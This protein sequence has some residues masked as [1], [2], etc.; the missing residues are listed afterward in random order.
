MDLANNSIL[1]TGAT[2]GLG[3]A[4]AEQFYNSGSTVI[5][6]GRREDRLQELEQQLPGIVTRRADVAVAQERE[7]LIAWAIRE[8]PS[9]NMLMNNAGMQLVTDVTKPVV[10]DLV[11]SEITTNL[12][13]PVHLASLAAQHLMTRPAAAIINISSGLAF[14][15]LAFMPIYCATKAAIHS[16]TMSMRHQFRDTAVRVFEIIPPSVDTELGHQRRSDPSQ[17]H[18]GMPIEEFIGPAMEA[19]ASDIYEA[20]IGPAKGL[21]ENGE[22]MFERMNSH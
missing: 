11:E 4:F 17:S 16:L 14:A 19:I 6:C 13:A 15:P 21:R 8:H 18:G 10:L 20:P 1:I 22:K 7:D 9:F 2:S 3:R 5:A 12:T